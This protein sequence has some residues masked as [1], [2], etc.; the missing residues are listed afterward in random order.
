MDDLLAINS[1]D[2]SDNALYS[3]LHFVFNVGS[4]GEVDAAGLRILTDSEFDLWKTNTNHASLKGIQ[5]VK[6]AAGNGAWNSF[7][8]YEDA[9]DENGCSHM[10]VTA[11]NDVK[12]DIA[13]WLLD[14]GY[15]DVNDVFTHE[16]TEGD[17]G[18]LVAKFDVTDKWVYEAY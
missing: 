5:V 6:D 9:G 11:L 18:T 14:N 10:S 15:T 3:N 17:I 8:T 12:A 16:K 1:A 13:G 2:G 4:N 7:E